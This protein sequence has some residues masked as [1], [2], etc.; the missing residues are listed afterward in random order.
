MVVS[1][2]ETELLFLIVAGFSLFPKPE[3]SICSHWWEA[4]WSLNRSAVQ[5]VTHPIQAISVDLL[6]DVPSSP[7]KALS[8]PSECWILYC[9]WTHNARL[10]LREGN[11]LFNNLMIENVQTLQGRWTTDW[12]ESRAGRFSRADKQQVGLW[13][14]EAGNLLGNN[15]LVLKHRPEAKIRWA[16]KKQ[17]KSWV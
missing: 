3:F 8:S 6:A 10:R 14:E 1:R 9:S 15:T 7:L 13:V 11:K 17:V 4:C 2:D 12:A 5:M 16:D